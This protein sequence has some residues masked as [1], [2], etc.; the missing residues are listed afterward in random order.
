MPSGREAFAARVALVQAAERSIDAQYYIWHDDITGA[1]LMRALREAA[2]RGVRVRLLLDDNNTKGLDPAIAMLDAHPQI[3][4]RLFNPFVNRGSRLAGY[5]T[6]FSRLNRRMH[7]KSFTV[8]NQAT[9]VGGRNIGDEY[10]GAADEMEFAD[11]DVM[12]A[13]AVVRDVSA[14]FDAYWNSASAYPAAGIVGGSSPEAEAQ[15]LA[16]WQRTAERAARQQVRRGGARHAAGAPDAHAT[17]CRSN[18]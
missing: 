5:L 14:Q 10:F 17:R 7:N 3:E 1:T 2:D 8:D 16:R 18:G 15:V 11:L 12:A 9:I 4:V 6:D 13:G